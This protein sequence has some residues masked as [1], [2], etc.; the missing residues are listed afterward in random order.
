MI[1]KKYKK[2]VR[3]Y[4]EQLF[5]NKL[6]NLEEMDKFL[7]THSLPNLKQE[8]MVNWNRTVTILQKQNVTCNKQTNKIFLQTE[9]QDQMAFLGNSTKHAKN[10]TLMLLKLF[11]ETEE[12]EVFPMSF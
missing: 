1:L 7:E 2:I 9:V 11:Q 6:D 5:A 3:K 8:D 10:L 4:Y 12:E